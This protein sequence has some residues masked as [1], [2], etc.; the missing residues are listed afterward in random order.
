VFLKISSTYGSLFLA[1]QPQWPRASSFLRFLEHTQRRITVGRTPLDEWSARSRALYLT[2]HNDHKRQTSMLPVGFE[3]TISADE[4]PQ[5]A[6]DRAAIRTGQLTVVEIVNKKSTYERTTIGL[7]L[8]EKCN[9]CSVYR[10]QWSIDASFTGSVY[11]NI[12]NHFTELLVSIQ[13]YWN[14]KLQQQPTR[15]KEDGSVY[16]Y[17]LAPSNEKTSSS[18]CL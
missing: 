8:L 4:R 12:R 15:K 16:S 9:K 3:P 2:T 7:Y 17:S 14:Q 18:P 10:R 13:P 6:A 11:I 5:T 1:Q